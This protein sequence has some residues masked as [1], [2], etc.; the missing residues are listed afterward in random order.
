MGAGNVVL[1]YLNWS[2]LDS[3]PFR[4]LGFMAVISQDRMHPPIYWG[5]RDNLVR[6]MGR[7]EAPTNTDY[8]ALA[9]VI[10]KLIDEGAI[11]VDK[12]AHRGSNAVY[13]LNLDPG[14][15]GAE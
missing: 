4:V 3:V 14:K 9:R 12:P 8:R 15:G 1:A 7:V 5:G 2:H 10:S 6:A 13:S 11:T